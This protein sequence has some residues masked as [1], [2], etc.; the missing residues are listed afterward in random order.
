VST[1]SKKHKTKVVLAREM[2]QV[3]NIAKA[4]TKRV[5]NVGHF[6]LA[7]NV[8]IVFFVH[9]LHLFEN[10]HWLVDKWEFKQ[11]ITIKLHGE[12]VDY[13]KSHYHIIKRLQLLGSMPNLGH[14]LQ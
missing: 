5:L 14:Q 11:H 7:L 10:S 8:N 12:K 9:A 2:A 3:F 1:G 6:H 13:F 4:Q